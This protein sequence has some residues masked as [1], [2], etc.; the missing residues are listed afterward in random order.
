M[1]TILYVDACVN[2]TTSRTE[3]LARA[4]L[5]RLAAGGD[6]VEELVLEELAIEPLDSAS[7]NE[8]TRLVEAGAFDGPVFDLARQFAQVDEVVFAA[9]YWDFSFPSKLKVYLEHLCAQG[10]TF[11]YSELGIPTGLCRAQRFH[12]V[13]TAGGYI[14]EY[15][16]GY[17]QVRAIC[18]LYFGIPAGTRVAAEGL[19]I[20][21]NDV[22]AIMAA[23]LSEME[24]CGL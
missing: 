3:R 17:E 20:V 21:G 8:R 22:E 19:D 1:G 9:P 14:G 23:A 10:V 5:E 6:Q 4:L 7:L 11:T 24:A 18:E 15:D 13:T 2:R 16:F 12:Y